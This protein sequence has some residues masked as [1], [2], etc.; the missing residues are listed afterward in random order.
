MSAQGGTIRRGSSAVIPIQ[1]LC[2]LDLDI[3]LDVKTDT[4]HGWKRPAQ[5]DEQH[6]Y[7][8]TDRQGA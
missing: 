3:C 2:M 5:G 8:T 6:A 7:A 1:A 4:R